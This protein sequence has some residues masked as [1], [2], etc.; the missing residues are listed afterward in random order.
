MTA[1]AKTTADVPKVRP[2]T[3]WGK[4]GRPFWKVRVF[5]HPMMPP[6][7]VLYPGGVRF[8][9]RRDMDVVVPDAVYEVL[10]QTVTPIGDFYPDE[11]DGE[12]YLPVKKVNNQDITSEKY[13]GTIVLYPM[14]VN[15][16]ATEDEF[17]AQF[18]KKRKKSRYEEDEA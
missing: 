4:D 10:K 3:L 5:N 2:K 16:Q 9:F 12:W 14:Q 15:G 18:R 13:A 8:E 11:G 6:Q 7:V 17:L 1:E